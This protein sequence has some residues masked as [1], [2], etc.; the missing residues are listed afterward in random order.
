MALAQSHLIPPP[1]PQPEP[2][3]AQPSPAQPASPIQRHPIPFISADTAAATPFRPPST[4]PVNGV[5]WLL[6][7]TS[8][9]LDPSDALI[10]PSPRCILTSLP[11]PAT[12]PPLPISTLGTSGACHDPTSFSRLQLKDTSACETLHV[13]NC[14][15][16]CRDKPSPCG[17]TKTTIHTALALT[18]GIR[19]RRL[20]TRLPRPLV[21]VSIFI[22]VSPALSPAAQ[23]GICRFRRWG[24]HD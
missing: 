17:T 1:I 20:S 2:E 13:S 24:E 16:D 19:N 14:R 22:P 21:I 7:S 11:I 5:E 3:P 10:Q 8:H 6:P 4:P 9:S 12:P 18:A 23:D 15:R